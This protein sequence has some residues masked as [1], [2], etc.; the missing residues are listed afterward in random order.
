MKSFK[1][2]WIFFYIVHHAF[3]LKVDGAE[4]LVP[5]LYVFGDSSVDAG[6]NNNLHTHAKANVPPYGIDFNNNATGRFTN[7]KTFADLIAIKLG[8]P[9]QPSYLGISDSKRYQ[10]ITGINYASG[11][12]GILNDTRDGECLSLD[13]QIEYFTSTVV[14]NLP[15]H[16]HLKS[17]DEL[18]HHLSKSIYLISIGS[19]DYF[20][21]YLNPQIRSYKNMNPEEF[22]D[23]LLE[24]L[25]SK[26][27]TIYNL[28]ARKF[29]V[30]TVNQV[31]CSPNLYC[32]ETI[33]QMVKP[34]SDK[35]LMKVQEMEK[36][37]SG[38]MFVSSNGFNFFN[39]IKN[40]PKKY[41][42][43]NISKSC[44]Q[45]GIPCA[46]RKEHYFW[47]FGHITEAAVDI[48][49]NECFSGSKM[50]FPDVKKLAHADL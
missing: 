46:N 6:N 21:N 10:V 2:F 8:L 18:K 27:K 38:S 32:N 26:I 34:C 41:G 42:F 11:A 47:D 5:A 13:R 29:V 22:A 36:Q 4:S 7:G 40:D 3:F 30:G 14:N 37:F 43:A 17:K 20:L 24:Q 49:A 45:E 31:G 15:K 39:K 23:Y 28:G 12:C 1:A 19:N 44:I 9:L 25:S 50:C 16:K 33:N 35:L 48:Y